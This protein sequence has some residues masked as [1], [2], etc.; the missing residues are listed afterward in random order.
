MKE[1]SMRIAVM[2][3]GGTGGY[4]GGLLARAGEDVTFIAR[5][6]HLEAMRRRGL[7]VKSRLA[8]EFT[9]AV[10]ATN[11]PQE[12][13]P[14]DLILFCVKTYDTAAGVA[15]IGPLI[16]PETIVLPVQNGVESAERIAQ[17]VG[18]RTVI[19]GV[20]YVFSS[21]EAPGVVTQTAGAGRL[22]FG[23]LIEG[24]SPRTERLVHIF[25]RAGITAELCPDIRLALWEKFVNICAASGVTALTR[26]PIGPIM[27][28]ADTRALLQATMEEVDMVGRACGIRL[29]I[30]IVDQLGA[31][32][33]NLEPWAR[34]SLAHDLAAG[35]RLELEALNGAVVC[36]GR[37]HGIPTPM[38]FVIYAALKPYVDGAPRLP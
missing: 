24:N 3:A 31:F 25:K 19:G 5:G 36:L 2:G 38:N 4:F 29:P 26:L 28:C 12:L 18:A 9:Q 37:T 23:E 8:G 21:I 20:A 33:A 17:V 14:V 1:V 6:A 30:G 13:G 15:M 11:D 34:G 22:L 32:F 35:R 10:R 27:A 16:G 7:V